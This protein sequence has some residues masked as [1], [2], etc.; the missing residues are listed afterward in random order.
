MYDTVTLVTETPKRKQN[1]SVTADLSFIS[2]T[3]IWQRY[4]LCLI[5]LS[6]QVTIKRD[7]RVRRTKSILLKKNGFN[8]I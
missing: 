7:S 4:F 1:M 3:Y 2:D 6:L 8:L 5:P